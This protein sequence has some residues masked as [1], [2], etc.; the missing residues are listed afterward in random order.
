MDAKMDLRAEVIQE[1]NQLLKGTHMGAF[2]FEDLRE[3]V[4][5]EKLRLE[6]HRYLELLKNHEDMLTKHITMIGGEP[7]DTS[8]FMGTITDMMSMIKNM[9][10]VGDIQVVEEAVKAIE[11]GLKAIR[12]FDD[13][14][15]TLSETMRKEIDIMKDDYQMIY[16]SLHKYM[17]ANR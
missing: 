15:F 12:D 16:H 11:M 17:I 3:K 9:V 4:V 13:R 8:G 1:L 14:H 10:V 5:D 7:V 2:V 6:F